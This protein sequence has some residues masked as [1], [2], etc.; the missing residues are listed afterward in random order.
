MI[1]TEMKTI[2][3]RRTNRWAHCVDLGEFV[4]FWRAT[5]RHFELIGPFYDPGKH[6]LN[7]DVMD[8]ARDDRQMLHMCSLA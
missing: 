5:S 2:L 8:Y 1:K 6:T 3:R 7:R 4:D